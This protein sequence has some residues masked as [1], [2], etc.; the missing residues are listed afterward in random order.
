MEL[1]I[2]ERQ[3]IQAS[4]PRGMHQDWMEYQILGGRKVISRHGSREE[5]ERE[6]EKL[7]RPEGGQ[8]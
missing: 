8:R 7:K 4:P 1:R 3:R 6:L 5:A 2:R